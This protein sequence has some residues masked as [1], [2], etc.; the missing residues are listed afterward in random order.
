LPTPLLSPGET[1]S[2][3]FPLS[4]IM[5]SLTDHDLTERFV[6]REELVERFQLAQSGRLE[7]STHM[8]G[9]KQFEPIS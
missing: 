2:L 3:S 7:L 8:F 5:F 1:G 9:N 6:A 4:A